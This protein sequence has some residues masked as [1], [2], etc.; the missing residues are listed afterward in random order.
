MTATSHAGH[1]HRVPVVKVAGNRAASTTN[2]HKLPGIRGHAD[3]EFGPEG[4]GVVTVPAGNAIVDNLMGHGDQSQTHDGR[5]RALRLAK[6]R[7]V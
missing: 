2:G 7:H 4:G 3:T 5:P 1:F 6:M